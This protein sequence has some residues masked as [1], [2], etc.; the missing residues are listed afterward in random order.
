MA[1]LFV[2]KG[3][4]AA[5]ASATAFIFVTLDD[6]DARDEW[7]RRNLRDLTNDDSDRF[8]DLRELFILSIS[9]L[10]R[11]RCRTATATHQGPI[12]IMQNRS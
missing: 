7:L 5:A 2:K 1:E 8:S 9:E 6:E 4:F 3:V 10:K 11:A 12:G